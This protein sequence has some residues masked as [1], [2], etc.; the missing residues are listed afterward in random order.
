MCSQFELIQQPADLAAR[1]GLTAPPPGVNMSVIRPTDQ[2]MVIRMSGK[3]ML[4][5]WGF[6]VSWDTKPIINARSESLTEKKTFR[7]HLENRCIVPA[8]GYFEWRKVNGAK[9]KNRI[10]PT[11]QKAFG[12]A[13]LVRDDRFTIITCPPSP[14]IAHIHNRMPV[15]L[16]P[17]SERDWLDPSQDFK[18]V[19][20]HLV[21]YDQ[22]PMSAWEDQPPPP[23]QGDMF[24]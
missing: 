15:I 3:A 18:S 2:A 23:R 8:T 22:A 9:H 10:R 13:G 21:P 4:Y 14:D 19:A 12:M 1:F 7:P 24:G 16:A 6:D 20:H 17:G 5:G 11:D